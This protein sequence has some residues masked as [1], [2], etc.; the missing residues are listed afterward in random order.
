MS[1]S[2]THTVGA[3]ANPPFADEEDLDDICPVCDGEC[4]CANR[5]QPLPSDYKGNVQP[6]ATLASPSATLVPSLQSLKIKLTVPPGMLS[7]ARAAQAHVQTNTK[8]SK[9]LGDTMFDIADVG[10]GSSISARGYNTLVVSHSSAS[11]NVPSIPKRRGRPPKATRNSAKLPGQD[12]PGAFVNEA[13]TLP[14]SLSPSSSKNKAT[15]SRASSKA[16]SKVAKSTGNFTTLKKGKTIARSSPLKRKATV[17]SD[18]NTESDLTD[19]DEQGFDEDGIDDTESIHYPTF[20]SASAMS[21]STFSE[22]SETASSSSGFDSDT[23]LEAEEENFILKEERRH[24]KARVRRELL[25]GD[26]HKRKDGYNNWV[27]RARKQSVDPEDVEMEID[28]DASED[29]E[30]EEE[31]D[32]EGEEDDEMDES[33]PGYYA[34]VATGWSDEDEESSFDADLFF[35]NLSDSTADGDSTS[36]DDDELADPNMDAA[37]IGPTEGGG[38][39]QPDGLPF[40]VSHGWDGQI[41]FTNGVS[42]GHALLNHD[43]ELSAAQLVDDSA[44][45]SQDSDVEMETTEGEDDGEYEDMDDQEGGESDGGDSTDDDY[46]GSNGL[47]TQRLLELFRWPASLSAIDPMSTVSP[48]VSPSPHNRRRKRSD[49][50][51]S[52]D[53]HSPRPADILAGKIFWADLDEQGRDNSSERRRPLPTRGGLPVMGRFEAGQDHPRRAILN[54]LNKDVPSPFPRVKHKKR[55]SSYSDCVSRAYQAFTC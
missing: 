14:S 55:T 3:D 20:I 39:V 8:K 25:G 16:Q 51:S 32:D 33:N 15:K 35:A 19:L 9:H 42:E 7:K 43:F 54:G 27:I 13:N 41:V 50:T 28:S 24:E 10:E 18:N 22:D 17:L 44:T 45:P 38:R 40:E 21:T 46:V 36:V 23:S 2:H 4:T 30:E 52:K 5:S 11:G 26:G 48:T 53:S 37:M 1:P 34:G 12:R 49:T 47:P 31:G 29:E 6:A